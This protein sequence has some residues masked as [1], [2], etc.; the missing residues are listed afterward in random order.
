MAIHSPLGIAFHPRVFYLFP[1]YMNLFAFPRFS[2][3]PAHAS[4]GNLYALSAST[5][6]PFPLL[7]PSI[8]SAISRL[9]L[10]YAVRLNLLVP[11]ITFHFT[12]FS[13]RTFVEGG[14][15]YR[16]PRPILSL[17]TGQYSTVR[18]RRS[19]VQYSSDAFHGS[20][21]PSTPQSWWTTV[22]TLTLVESSSRE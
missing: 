11:T 5:P 21:G 13:F 14:A 15:A 7:Y 6:P 4:C 8:I 22:K 9:N 1:I 10:L 20:R 12:T 17:S 16:R 3:S 19:T 18:Y 2:T